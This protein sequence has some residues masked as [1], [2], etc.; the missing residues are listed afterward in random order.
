LR[1]IAQRDRRKTIAMLAA[2]RGDAAKLGDEIRTPESITPTVDHAFDAKSRYD[3]GFTDRQRFT[4]FA[5]EC[6][7]SRD[8]VFRHGFERGCDL[9]ALRRW[10]RPKLSAALKSHFA[11][12]QRAGLV[13]NDAIDLRERL[14]RIGMAH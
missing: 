3:A 11:A 5:R 6:E 13:E 8:R 1:F 14:D 9:Q 10:K 4:S 12:G 7:R 2:D